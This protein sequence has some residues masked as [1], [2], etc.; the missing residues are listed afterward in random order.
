M[1]AASLVITMIDVELLLIIS[2]RNAGPE[3]LRSRPE[4]K[5]IV[6]K[7]HLVLNGD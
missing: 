3:C 1:A 6:V 5:W 7:D 2:D 4:L